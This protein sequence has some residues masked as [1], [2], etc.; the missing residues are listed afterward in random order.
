M[1]SRYA[2]R[3]TREQFPELRNAPLF[4]GSL[5]PDE[6]VTEA[7]ERRTQRAKEHVILSRAEPPRKKQRTTYQRPFPSSSQGPRRDDPPRR[8]VIPQQ[9]ARQRSPSPQRNSRGD[10][11]Q[12]NSLPKKKPAKRFR[13]NKKGQ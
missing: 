4:S 5:I 8:E 10:R 2:D 7:I 9:Q 13:N 11:R 12:R 3:A 6:Q 1:F